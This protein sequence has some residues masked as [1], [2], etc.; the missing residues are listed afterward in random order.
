MTREDSPAK[1]QL[2]TLRAALTALAALIVAD[3]IL[4][5]IILFIIIKYIH[6]YI[7]YVRRRALS[8]AGR[9]PKH[10]LNLKPLA[11]SYIFIHNKLLFVIIKNYYPLLSLIKL[12]S[13]RLNRYFNTP[14]LNPVTPS[15]TSIGW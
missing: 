15:H 14:S 1:H 4:Y 9:T 7:H 13:S 6:Y 5:V 8:T 12:K 2:V 11:I 3:A 10:S